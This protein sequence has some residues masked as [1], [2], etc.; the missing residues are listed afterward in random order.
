MLIMPSTNAAGNVLARHVGGSKADFVAL[1]NQK[2]ADL[3]L[4]HSHFMNPHGL[5]QEGHYVSAYDM[6]V[7]LKACMANE[8]CAK[9]LGASSYKVPATDY[10][11]EREMYSTNPFLNGS[12]SFDQVLGTKSGFTIDACSTLVT[13]IERNHRKYYI[14][15]LH[16]EGANHYNDTMRLAYLLCQKLNIGTY[17]QDIA[18]VY[19][20]TCTV[21][22]GFITIS[23]DVTQ[24]LKS[25]RMIYWNEESG[26]S[27]AVFSGDVAVSGNHIQR[28]LAAEKTGMYTL[29]FFPVTTYGQELTIVKTILYTEQNHQNEIVSFGGKN[30]YI[31]DFGFVKIGVIETKN[32]CYY[33]ADSSA[34]S[35]G[36]V[37][38]RF[39][40]G[41][42]GKVVTGWFTVDYEKYYAGAD[43]RIVTG[44][45]IIGNKLYSFDKDGM[46]ED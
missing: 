10:T 16:S 3:G 30:Y 42:D 28:T 45:C 34:I 23:A 6:T 2:L 36:F 13:C 25:Y 18:Y 11:E 31:D 26:T 1:M 41:S 46:L 35:Y 37:G 17:D 15:T 39:Y 5:D 9:I 33:A 20:L 44:D 27:S 8:I 7:I 40:A 29:Q 14:C 21:T 32:G 22:D 4:S 12:K 38:G 43:G 24:P 19:N